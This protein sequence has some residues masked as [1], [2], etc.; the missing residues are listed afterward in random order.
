VVRQGEHESLVGDCAALVPMT[1]ASCKGGGTGWR[2]RSED[3]RRCRARSSAERGTGSGGF[4]RRRPNFAPS[5]HYFRPTGVHQ[6]GFTAGS[7]GG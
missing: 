2:K 6:E 3:V 4:P 1:A 5:R 7:R